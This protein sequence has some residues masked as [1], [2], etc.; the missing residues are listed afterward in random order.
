MDGAIIRSKL[1]KEI[2]ANIQASLVLGMGITENAPEA[3]QRG[4]AMLD[5]VNKG[6]FEGDADDLLAVSAD[7]K[8][9]L[10]ALEKYTPATEKLDQQRAALFQQMREQLER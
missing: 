10:A 3:M 1:G 2:R 5:Q 4:T 6:N 8:K 9:F 7:L